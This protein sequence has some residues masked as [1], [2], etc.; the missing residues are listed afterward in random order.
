[1]VLRIYQPVIGALSMPLEQ[2]LQTVAT[3]CVSLDQNEA[4]EI[5]RFMASADYHPFYPISPSSQIII[6]DG[7]YQHLFGQRRTG[8][9]VE[10]GAYDGETFSNTSGLSD[11][12][13]RGIYVEPIPS[14]FEQCRTRHAANSGVVVLNIAIGATSSVAF[15]VDQGPMTQIVSGA[16][17][18]AIKV[19][20]RRLDDVLAEQGQAPG[21]DLLVVD[22][23]GF[24]GEV[25]AGFDLERWRPTV[26]II[27]LSELGVLDTAK[28]RIRQRI[29]A[30]GY[31][32]IF[33]DA[34][35]S[36]FSLPPSLRA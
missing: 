17:A 7:L 34:I 26:I 6:L 16:P 1:M 28:E 20:V 19:E 29:L 25:F 14:T 27:E 4:A 2:C 24:E 15:M 33:Q 8:Q 32:L 18:G 9:F 12:G 22:V 23:E 36:L 3:L 11:L 31:R 10:I 30:A 35:N 21:F 5:A 13:W